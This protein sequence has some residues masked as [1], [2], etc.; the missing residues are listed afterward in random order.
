MTRRDEL[1]RLFDLS[2]DVLL[3]TDSG[4]AHSRLAGFVSRRFDLD[5]AAICVPHAAGMDRLP[6]RPSGTD[7]RSG[8]SCR[9]RL[10]RWTR[11]VDR[12]RVRGRP[13]RAE[14]RDP[15]CALWC[16]CGWAPSPSGCSRPPAA[17][18]NPSTLAA[19]AGLAAIAIERAQFLDERKAAELARQSE[20][21][22]SALLASLGHDLRTPL[23]AIRVAAGNLQ[24]AWPSE[25]ERREQSDVILSE[26][27]RL[28]RLFENILEM[29]RIDAGAVTERYEMGGPVRDRRG[30]AEPGGTR[31][32]GPP[33]RSGRRA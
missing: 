5:Y 20:E 7:A 26:V 30:G 27:E 11:R 33:D 28:T 29:A 8:M 15:R 18:S 3:I 6:G 14:R 9:R 19:V 25:Q 13:S 24:A 12:R 1:G 31:A 10:R 4:E 21:L 16:R 23:T 22:K 17:R 32:A 2:R